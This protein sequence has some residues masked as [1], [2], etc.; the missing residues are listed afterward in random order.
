ME[1][2]ILIFIICVCSLFFIGSLMMSH[3]RYVLKV[4][5]RA[6]LGGVFMYIFNGIL[7]LFGIILPLGINALTVG[8]SGILGVP[9]LMLLYGVGFFRM[10]S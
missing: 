4:A 3:K 9:G 6:C 5:A 7:T 2:K 1:N 8:I 10:L